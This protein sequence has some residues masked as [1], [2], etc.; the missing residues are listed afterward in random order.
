MLKIFY[1]S[2]SFFTVQEMDNFK[3]KFGY[4]ISEIS[5]SSSVE[6]DFSKKEEKE[7]L[8]HKGYPIIS[9]RFYI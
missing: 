9:A 6:I 3:D 1:I 5:Y 8:F 7:F 4:S 2:K